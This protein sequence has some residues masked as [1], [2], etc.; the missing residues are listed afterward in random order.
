MRKGG[1]ERETEREREKEIV[2]IVQVYRVRSE[3]VIEGLDKF[4]E[5]D[6]ESN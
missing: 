3:K 5:R 2:G 6:N 1:R 4:P